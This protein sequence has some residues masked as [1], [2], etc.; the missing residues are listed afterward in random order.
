MV[1]DHGCRVAILLQN[2]DM[3]LVYPNV[4]S[5][6][7]ERTPAF[8]GVSRVL[9]PCLVAGFAIAYLSHCEGIAFAEAT[10]R[11][12]FACTMLD[13]FFSFSPLPTTAK[14]EIG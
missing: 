4:W 5:G 8:Y 2:Y 13:S 7:V 9:G 3:L 10:F 12:A 1:F 6:K 11:H 14:W